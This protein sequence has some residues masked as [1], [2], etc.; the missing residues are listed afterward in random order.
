MVSG[1]PGT[2][3]MEGAGGKR[4]AL[5]HPLTKSDWWFPRGRAGWWGASGGCRLLQLDPG[6]GWGVGGAVTGGGGRREV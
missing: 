1:A 6:R 4:A 3:L 2:A 5:C